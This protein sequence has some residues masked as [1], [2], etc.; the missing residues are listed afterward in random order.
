MTRKRFIKLLMSDPIH[1]RR[2][3]NFWRGFVGHLAN[4]YNPHCWSY[5]TKYDYMIGISCF[6][7]NKPEC[8]G[9]NCVLWNECD[10][11]KLITQ[12][13]W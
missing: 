3:I 5:Q 1:R 13:L 9:E 6:H 2:G 7:Y 8:K 10:K 12:T 4:T 11:G